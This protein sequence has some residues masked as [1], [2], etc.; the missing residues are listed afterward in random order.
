MHICLGIFLL[1][2]VLLSLIVLDANIPQFLQMCAN[3]HTPLLIERSWLYQQYGH[4]GYLLCLM[5]IEFC[6]FKKSEFLHVR[7]M[8]Y[9][10]KILS[11]FWKK[12]INHFILYIHD[13]NGAFR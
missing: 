11:I 12:S 5:L 1:F 6:A 4:R 7:S 3:G 8:E 13:K 10:M 9:E 2:F